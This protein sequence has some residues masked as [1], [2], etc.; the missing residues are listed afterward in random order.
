MSKA[1][2]STPAPYDVAESKK[3]EALAILCQLSA[4]QRWEWLDFGRMLVERRKEQAN[5]G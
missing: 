4:Q 1:K 2:P 3:R 5:H